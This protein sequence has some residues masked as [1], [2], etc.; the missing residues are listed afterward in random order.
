VL[1]DDDVTSF[2]KYYKA[3]CDRHGPNLYG[4][5]KAWCDKYFYLPMRSEHRGTGGI[6]FDD[7]QSLEGG[8][9]ALQFVKGVADGFMPSYLPIVKKRKDTKATE[10]QRE[11]MLV[12]RG[13]Y[14]EFNRKLATGTS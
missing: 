9:D 1:Y 3:V 10:K 13:R 11:W 7:L 12:R 4:E 5:Y 2:H 14:L 6:F 8:K